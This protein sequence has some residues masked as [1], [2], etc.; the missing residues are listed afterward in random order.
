MSN[1]Q[2]ARGASSCL[3]AAVF[4]SATRK[5]GSGRLPCLRGGLEKPAPPR[6]ETGMHPSARL[7]NEHKY[8]SRTVDP[9]K[10]AGDRAELPNGVDDDHG[11]R[12]VDPLK[13]PPVAPRR[14]RRGGITTVLA[15]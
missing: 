2:S 8:G 9:L 15:P 4:L 1:M 6:A 12:T 5:Q 14:G 13:L 7:E 3:R 11:S 10:L